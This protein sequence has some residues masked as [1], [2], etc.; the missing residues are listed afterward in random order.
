[1]EPGRS[2]RQTNRGRL[3]NAIPPAL[4]APDANPRPHRHPWRVAFALQADGWYLRSDIIWSKPNHA[5][6]RDRSADEEP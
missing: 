3:E 2:M 5:R 4:D 1:M 6:E